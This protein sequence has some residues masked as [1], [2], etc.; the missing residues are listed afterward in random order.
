M[1]TINGSIE[2]VSFSEGIGKDKKPYS[3]WV[4]LIDGKKYSTFNSEIG[5]KFKAGQNVEMEGEKSGAF[6]NMQTMKETAPTEKVASAAPKSNNGFTTMYVSYAKDIFCT[7]M[8]EVSSS[9]EVQPVGTDSAKVIMN[10]AIALVKQ[11]KEAFEN[12]NQ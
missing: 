3:R 1:E 4:F 10:R 7:L 2:S 5:T 12:G 9:F 6:W 8:P 11:A